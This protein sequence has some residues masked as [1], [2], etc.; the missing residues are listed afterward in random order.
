MCVRVHARAS[1]KERE[2]ERFLLTHEI[3]ELKQNKKDK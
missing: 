1:G 2:R 3:V